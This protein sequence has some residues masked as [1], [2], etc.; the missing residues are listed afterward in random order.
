MQCLLTKHFG[1]Q[2]HQVRHCTE[3]KAKD[4]FMTPKSLADKEGHLNYST[5]SAGCYK[6]KLQIVN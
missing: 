3:S 4:C 2:L 1:F 5:F 6:L